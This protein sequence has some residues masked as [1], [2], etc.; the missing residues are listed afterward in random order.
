MKKTLN[1]TKNT[2]RN[3]KEQIAINLGYELKDID[4]LVVLEPNV[5]LTYIDSINFEDDRDRAYTSNSAY[6]AIFISKKDKKY[7]GST[8]EELFNKRQTY[9]AEK[10]VTEFENIYEN[11]KAKRL[12][13]DLS[14]LQALYTYHP[15]HDV[16]GQSQA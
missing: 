3:V 1:S 16:K 12:L 9:T 6:T 8:G 7:P 2:Y 4:K 10:V 11:L 5:D 13:Y 14:Q 15:F